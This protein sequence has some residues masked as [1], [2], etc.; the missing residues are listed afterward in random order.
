MAIYAKVSGGDRWR[1]V[2]HGADTALTF[3]WPA[4]WSKNDSIIGQV[5]IELSFAP[6]A[7]GAKLTRVLM[8]PGQTAAR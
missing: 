8:Y 5:A 3:E 7:D 1:I 2:A 6:G 4:D